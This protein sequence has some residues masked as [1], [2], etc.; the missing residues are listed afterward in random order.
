[1]KF[2]N[3]PTK[4]NHI[5]INLSRKSILYVDTETTEKE[6]F[7]HIEKAGID[8]Y[9]NILLLLQI[10]DGEETYIFDCRKIDIRF[11]API[12]SDTS[13]TKVIQNAKF[14]C[15]Q[16]KHH[17]NINTYGIFDTMLAE[18]LLH[19]GYDEYRNKAKCS[20]EVLSG[21]Y[22]DKTISK[23]VRDSFI[24]F[25]G[26]FTD[27]QLRYAEDDATILKPIY[28]KQIELL[29]KENLLRVMKLENDLVPSV[30]DMEL[31]GFLLDENRLKAYLEEVN[32]KQFDIVQVLRNE[33]PELPI[34]EP[35][36]RAKKIKPPPILNLDS[37]QQL[38]WAFSEIGIKLISTN[39][40]SI[41]EALRRTKREELKHLLEYKKLRQITKSFGISLLK[42]IHPVTGRVHASFNQLGTNTGRF[43]CDSPNHQQ[44]PKD[45]KM[46]DCFI[47][48]PRYK[49]VIA[50]FSQIEIRIAA[51]RSQD[52][53]LLG[54]L[55]K[56][57]DIHTETGMLMF[58]KDKLTDEER[59]AA[60]SLNFGIFYGLG[61]SSL[62]YRL[63]CSDDRA[64]ELIANY[65]S[66][67]PQLIKWL[68]NTGKNSFIDGVSK[69]IYGR[70]RYFKHISNFDPNF[71]QLRAA[72]EREGKNMPIQGE[73]G[74]IL[75]LAMVSIHKELSRFDAG[76]VNTVHD[77]FEY[78][79]PEDK[80]K[81]LAKVV[82]EKM[83]EAGEKFIIDCPIT[84]DVK[85]QDSWYK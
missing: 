3:E 8:P 55:N 70:K 52:H 53:N 42:Y 18:K 28:E 33:L 37:W 56:G 9:L 79:V 69:T 67:Y 51:Q 76:Q 13:I 57:T 74:D 36:P 44:I 47:A 7:S 21:K 48:K 6:E 30:V 49:L 84:V 59:T 27:E 19:S 32:E 24:G 64:K 43:S 65:K 68:D 20:L 31:N 22:T 10:F 5:L 61:Y 14:D 41:K 63:E 62:A 39:E 72:T 58:N 29:K 83:I 77:E 38:I 54:A 82:E 40:R 16:L 12:F 34:P 1:L 2:I 85:I 75:K 11:L 15:A 60:K 23:S 71:R 73:C 78:E 4:L 25:K 26:D 50:D 66:T 35:N 80:A 81:A 45:G 17:F 46:R